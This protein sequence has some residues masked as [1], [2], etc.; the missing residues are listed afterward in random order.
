MSHIVRELL[1]ALVL[2]LLVFFV[3]QV[4]VQNFRVEGHSMQP[5]LDGSEYL[6]VNKLSYL[7]VD[8]Q[9]LAR[10]VP[11]WDV[12]TPE[13][14]FAPFS[15]PPRRGDVIVFHAP[16]RPERDFVKR[17]VGLPGDRV[18]IRAG[19]VYVNGDKL[20]EPYLSTSN[21]SGSMDCIPKL[22]A[23]NCT[24]PEN[25][26]FVLGD[27]RSS[28]NDS[29]DWGPVHLEGIVGKV[30]FVYWPL[31]RLPFVGSFVDNE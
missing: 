20:D 18:E 27:N 5:T 26:Y 31:S 23:S 7:R 1:E 21:L 12:K 22:Q 28:S 10:L 29:R 13:K 25:Q 14:K 15:H 19:A 2:A 24:L 16:T 17:V 8:M 3:I 4:S 9:R 30:W 6:M 11:F